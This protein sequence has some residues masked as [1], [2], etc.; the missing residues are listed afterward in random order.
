[1]E[2]RPRY[3]KRG[4]AQTIPRFGFQ[5]QRN[6]V[7]KG[8]PFK[9]SQPKGDASGKP[10]GRCFNCNEVSITPKIAPNPN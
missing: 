1:M 7:K 9:A 6:F 8:A 4:K 5:T 3:L 10:K 2:P